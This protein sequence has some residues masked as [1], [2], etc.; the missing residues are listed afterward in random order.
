MAAGPSKVNIN[1]KQFSSAVW[2]ENHSSPH[3]PLR[4][5]IQDEIPLKSSIRW[6]GEGGGGN[7]LKKSDR[8]V[9]ITEETAVNLLLL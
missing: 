3:S 9:E 2:C 8:M 5:Y 7:E 1:T 4:Y 6:R